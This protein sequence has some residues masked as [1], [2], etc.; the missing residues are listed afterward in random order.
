MFMRKYLY[1]CRLIMEK[2]LHYTWKHR[3]YPLGTLTTTDDKT[4]EVI[5]PGLHNRGDAGPDFFNAKI[6]VNG[7][8]WVGNVEIH[9]K[10]SDWFRHGH[11]K[12]AAYDNVILHVVTEA[13][14]DVTTSSGR[15]IPQMVLAIPE[16]LKTDYE[17][18]LHQDRYP[19]CYERIPD[20]PK[21]GPVFDRVAPFYFLKNNFH[22][23]LRGITRGVR[24]DINGL[25]FFS[26][27]H[28]RRV[29]RRMKD[30]F[31]RLLPGTFLP[32]PSGC[33]PRGSSRSRRFL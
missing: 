23:L 29:H 7:T 19:P 21:I 26:G 31:L 20:I 1:L 27:R 22:T 33:A 25:L 28:K 5:D 6:R 14:M 17:H 30:Y 32:A 15:M 18:L 4:V 2:L 3:L 11:D 13:D 9:L 12:D 16:R 24:L 8:E 10:A